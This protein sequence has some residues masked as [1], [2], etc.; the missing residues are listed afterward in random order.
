MRGNHRGPVNSPHKRP[1]TRKMFLFDDIIMITL[2]VC[3]FALKYHAH[4]SV[5]KQALASQLTRWDRDKIAGISQKTSLNAFFLNENIWISLKISL[6]F[7]PK[8][9][10]NNIPALVQIMAY[11]PLY[12]PMMVGLLTHICVIRPQWVKLSN[13]RTV[14]PSLCY[15]K[16]RQQKTTLYTG[17]SM[18]RQCWRTQ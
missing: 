2:Y 16:L 1:V 7:V 18:L 13:T 9:P 8:C 10:V 15:I 6:K 14:A 5:C 3:Y 4:I 11:K 12:E 17:G